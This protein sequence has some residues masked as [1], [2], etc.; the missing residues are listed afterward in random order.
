MVDAML[1]RL[2][3]IF[4]DSGYVKV[5]KYDP[6]LWEGRE[7]DSHLDFKMAMNKWA[8]APLDFEAACEAAEEGYRIGWVVPEGVCVIDID[9]QE[10]ADSGEY[11]LKV[12]DQQKV[13]YNWNRSFHGLHLVFRD[14]KKTQQS[15]AKVKCGLNIVIDTRA[16][17]TGYIVLPTN[18]P[19]REWGVWSDVQDILPPYLRA[20]GKDNTATFIGLSDGDGRND[21]IFKWKTK[22]VQSK[23]LNSEEI[24][25]TLKLINENLFAV[26]MT[27]KELNSISEPKEEYKEKKRGKRDKES[28]G[29]AYA[30]ELLS[31]YDIITIGDQFYI[32]ED[33]YYKPISGKQMEVLIHK[34]LSEDI[35]PFM[36]DI[37]KRFVSAKTQVEAEEVDKNWD[38][39]ACKNGILN[40]V[41]GELTLAN[42]NDFNTI[43][44]PW[45]WNGD[46]PPSPSIIEFMSQISGGDANKIQF[47]YEV[48]GYCLLKRNLYRKFF[49][50]QGPGGTGKSTFQR[51]IARLVGEQNCSYIGL[52]N[53]D[54]DYFLAKLANKLVN[55]D[56]DAVDGKSLDDSGRFKSVTAGERI[57]ARPIRE[58][59]RDFIPF[60]TCIF[61][62]NRLPRIMDTTT[63]LYSRI[64][65][66]ELNNVIEKP[67]P[68]FEEMLTDQDMEYFLY[69]AVK[70]IGEVIERGSF[71]INSTSEALLQRFKC[72]QSGVNE[73]LFDCGI[74]IKD[75]H[76]RRCQ[77]IY[78]QYVAWC[79]MN[80]YKNVQTINTFKEEVAAAMG[81]VVDLLQDSNGTTFFGFYCK[82]LERFK[83]D[84]DTPKDVLDTYNKLMNKGAF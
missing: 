21:A 49:I 75:L 60:C 22:L 78:S 33:N 41:S 10:V 64:I 67:I 43:H 4:P 26:P 40:V 63:G 81:M 35:E 66:V 82:E 48:V 32:Y 39:I 57:T 50:F 79:A 5:E 74:K 20:I 7:Y 77:T 9:N 18:D 11:V 62:C 70:A 72:R 13:K 31:R 51:L 69:K 1:E 14:P 80:G 29:N 3:K 52:N 8:S 38:Q 76:T 73:W 25:L 59:P 56:D 6:K 46:P 55:L 37:I 17:K 44:I 65:I 84:D 61:N 24:E 42:K 68:K 83:I 54:N 2:N 58:S 19:H 47:L 45:R 23:K 53:F 27:N 34:E 16:N 36:W 15:V 28:I 12:L 30:T 71:T